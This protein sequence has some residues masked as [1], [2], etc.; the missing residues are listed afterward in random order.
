MSTL[1]ELTQW[2]AEAS[3]TDTLVL[4]E[5]TVNVVNAGDRDATTR[6]H[7]QLSEIDAASIFPGVPFS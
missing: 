2:E 5:I 4:E 7:R 1:C 6:L 3:K